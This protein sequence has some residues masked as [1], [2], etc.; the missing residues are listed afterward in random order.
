VELLGRKA[1]GVSRFRLG[2]CVLVIL[3]VGAIGNAPVVAADSG[4]NHPHGNHQGWDHQRGNHEGERPMVGPMVQVNGTLDLYNA[5]VEQALDPVTGSIYNLWIAAFGIGFARSR[6]G[7][8][9]FDP[10]V[11]V[12]GSEDFFNPADPFN[13]TSSWDPAVVVSSDGIVYAAFMLSNWTTNPAGSPYVAVSF[14]HGASFRSAVPVVIPDPTSFSD[15]PFIA[16]SPEGTVYVTWNFAPDASL[17]QFLCTPG[18]SCSYS[19]GDFNMMITKSRDH[20]LTWSKPRHVSPNYPRGGSLEGPIV[21]GR[22]GELFVAYD[23]FPTAQDYSLSAG[24]EWFTSS[25]NGG[26]TWSAPVLLSDTYRVDLAVWWIE[27][28]LAIDR[29]GTLYTAFDVQTAQGDI[30]FVRYSLDSGRTWSPLIR[31]TPDVDPATHMMQIVPGEDGTAYVA[32]LSNNATSG[33]WAVYM[34][35]LSTDAGTVSDPIQVSSAFGDPLWWP[36]DTIGMSFLGDDTVSVSWGAQI[37][38]DGSNDGIFNVVV[39]F[40]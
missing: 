30:G 6:D 31:A 1:V 14:D 21:I 34:A 28:T 26:K 25:K 13:S 33:A 20:G 36:G 32:W 17:I 3:F 37:S 10:A 19:A 12:P 22:H 24:Q 7:G 9:S 23:A 16:V 2:V 5:E 27:N 8:Q 11:V 38:P 4:T 15:R 40:D 29:D 35:T 39:Q 18:G